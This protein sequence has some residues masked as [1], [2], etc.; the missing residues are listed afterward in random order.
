MPPTPGDDAD[1][2]GAEAEL[3]GREEQVRRPEDAPQDVRPAVGQGE[4]PQHRRAERRS[5]CRRGSRAAPARDRRRGVGG[6][7]FF[8][9]VAEQQRRDDERDGVDGDRDRARVKHLDQEAADPERAELGHRA[10]SPSA[11]CSP[12]RAARA[13]RRSAGR[14]CRR[15]RRTSRGP[16]RRRPRTSSCGRPSAS[17]H[18][19]D[20]D[21]AEE[22][23]PAEVGP[24]QDRP[25][26]EP[27]DPGA[28]EQPDDQ[29]GDQLGRADQRDLD[30]ARRRGR[31]S[32]RTAAPSA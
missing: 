5:A 3:L 7:S 28:G 27:V 30:R 17:E 9:I 20:R 4:R 14:R 26:A 1:R 22:H 32:P 8:R 21:R 23:G 24:D 6:G 18:E 12:R 31:G 10:A 25:A 19:G 11:R 29:A 13:R 15:R 2:G 16:P